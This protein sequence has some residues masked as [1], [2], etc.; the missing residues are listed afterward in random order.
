M[1]PRPNPAKFFASGSLSQPPKKLGISGPDYRTE[2]GLF[3]L[4]RPG[5]CHAHCNRLHKPC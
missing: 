4:M 5:G 1:F 2:P 3:A